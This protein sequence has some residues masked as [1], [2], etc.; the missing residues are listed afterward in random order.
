MPKKTVW[1]T[2][3]EVARFGDRIHIRTLERFEGIEYFAV[4]L[5]EEL[6]ATH[7]FTLA[8]SAIS[9][10]DMLLITYETDDVTGTAFGC[11][12]SNCRKILAIRLTASRRPSILHLD[13]VEGEHRRALVY[14]SQRTPSS[15]PSPAVIYF[16]GHGGDIYESAGLCLFHSLWPEAVVVY[17]EGTKVDA[18]GNEYDEPKRGWQLRFPYK[19]A[20]G[21]TKDLTYVKRLLQ[22]VRE[23]HNVDSKRIYAVGHSSGGFFTFSL[24]ALMPYAFAKFAVLGAYSRFKVKLVS[25]GDAVENRAEPLTLT[26]QDHAT[27]PR[28]VFY[29]FGKNDTAF[30]ND[31]P[32]PEPGWHETQ[33]SRSRRTLVELAKRNA[34]SIPTGSFWTASTQFSP[35]PQLQQLGATVTWHLYDGDH[36]WPAA[37]SDLVV[38]FFKEG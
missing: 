21:Q 29:L 10:G 31:G 38:Q 13:D 6:L 36:S 9:S 18:H 5:S 32:S 30:N 37:A 25:A 17:A 35:P 19:H 12:G 33:M 4:P 14:P 8:G 26:Q 22:H 34:C 16:H 11:Q 2:P 1:C 24:M 27:L 28:P 7:A 23:H 20:L 3:T 15:E